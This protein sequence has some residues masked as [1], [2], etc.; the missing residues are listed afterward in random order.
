MA[1][2]TKEKDDKNV[3]Y[4]FDYDTYKSILLIG[5]G[6]F[7]PVLVKFNGPYLFITLDEF[8]SSKLGKLRDKCCLGYGFVGL[9]NVGIY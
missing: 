8:H 6:G 9:E 4:S 7:F 5:N 2:W 1:Q 3:K